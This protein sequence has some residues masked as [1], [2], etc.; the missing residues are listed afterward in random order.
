[1]LI[2][3]SGDL[4]LSA[5]TFAMFQETSSNSYSRTSIARTPMVRLPRLIRTQICVPTKFLT[6]KNKYLAKFS[7]FYHDVVCCVYSLE[8]PHRGDSNNYT[9]HPIIVSKIEK[10]SLIIAIC[11]TWFTLSGSSYPNLE[12]LSMVLKMFEPLKTDCIKI[13]EWQEERDQRTNERTDKRPQNNMDLQLLRN[14]G[15]RY[16]HKHYFDPGQ[17]KLAEVT[18]EDP[19]Q[20]AWSVCQ[21][22]SIFAAI[23]ILL[24]PIHREILKLLSYTPLENQCAKGAEM[25][26][27]LRNA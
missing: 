14:C 1:M 16:K 4:F 20:A 22:S 5:N 24:F 21:G 17:A 10:I 19:D 15:I 2:R 9:Q 13:S 7:F 11:L 8:S 18:S 26:G 12:Q 27:F 25:A 6:Q 23:G 3:L